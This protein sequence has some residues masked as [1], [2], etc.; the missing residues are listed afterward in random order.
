MIVVRIELHSEITGKVS[1]LGRLHISNDGEGTDERGN[2]DVV[3][4]GGHGT[5]LGVA[6]RVENYPRPYS[7]FRLL[8]K[9]LEALKV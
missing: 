7:V 4:F 9:A 2:Y 8:R 5:K 1:E 6:A 3:K